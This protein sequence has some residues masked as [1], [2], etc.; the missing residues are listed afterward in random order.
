MKGHDVE[1]AVLGAVMLRNDCFHEISGLLTVDCF[2]SRVHREI[3]AAIRDRI[4][5]G[6]PA[7]VITLGETNPG[8]VNQVLDITA[9]AFSAA[10]VLTYARMVREGWRRREAMRIGQEMLQ[11]VREAEDGA[12]DRAIGALLNL[13]AQASECEFTG[14]QLLRMANE[15]VSEAF[16]NGGKLPGITTGLTKLDELTGGLHKGDLF[17]V[18]ARPAMGKTAWLVNMAE[19]AAKAGHR[20]GVFTAEQPAVQIGLRRASLLSGVSATTLRNG[21][22][23]DEQWSRFNTIGN[24][25]DRQMWFYDRAAVSID[26]LVGV[27]RKWKHTHNVEALY[28]DYVQ[29]IQHHEKA[30]PRHERVGDI[31]ITLKNLARDL[32]I[33]VVALS[34]VK[35]SV[36]QKT[37][38]RPLSGDLAN[39]DELTRE[40]DE[41]VMLYRDEVYNRDTV[42]KGI[43]ELLVEKNRHGPTGFLKCA[44][45]GETMRFADLDIASEYSGNPDDY[46]DAPV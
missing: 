43:A 27:A 35:A 24:F 13:N 36:E 34:Q 17:V 32:G 15:A 8:I 44:F 25:V 2:T 26:E 45:V 39:S 1:S 21:R 5:A 23:D 4:V 28:V 31:A 42:D 30:M 16:N 14:K 7:D 19:A 12:V 33:P 10:N 37:D 3:W 46:M 9:S 11:A 22:L 20:V 18:G 41:I 38:K 40:A 29:R 6:E